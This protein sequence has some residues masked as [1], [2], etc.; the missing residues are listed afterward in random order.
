MSRDF[1]KLKVFAIADDLVVE[2]YRGTE[3]FPF[4][5]RFG[6]TAQIRRAAV[7]TA[8]CIVEGSARRSTREYLHFLNIAAASASEV[9]YLVE[10]SERLG[11]TKAKD[12]ERLRQ[13][14][15]EL[16]GGLQALIRTLT[17]LSL[18]P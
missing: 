16:I 2:I 4:A 3:D 7:S 1:R 12:C 13:R 6:L 10:L 5:E 9:R 8:S 17:P 18:E 15:T 11:F 14:Y